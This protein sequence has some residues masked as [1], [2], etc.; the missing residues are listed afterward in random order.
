[1]TSV[2]VGFGKGFASKR[3]EKAEVDVGGGI[4]FVI[5]RG[6]CVEKNDA[7]CISEVPI[8]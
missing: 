1:M 8:S 5:E 4:A 2:C 6:R 7:R 3:D